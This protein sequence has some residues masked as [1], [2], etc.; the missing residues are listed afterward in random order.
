MATAKRELTDTR[1][2]GRPE[3]L[4]TTEQVAAWLGVPKSFIYRRTCRGHSDPI[5]SYR[6][7][8]HLRFRADEVAEWIA[9]HRNRAGEAVIDAVST[10]YLDPPARSQK[11]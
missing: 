5:P 8:G 1:V 6:F 4:L 11:V 3:E 2:Q 9:E 10:I 7:G